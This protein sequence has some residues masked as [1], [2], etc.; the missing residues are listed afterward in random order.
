MRVCE[1]VC[2]RS[3]FDS[4]FEAVPKLFRALPRRLVAMV[5]APGHTKC[6]TKHQRKQTVTKTTNTA[7]PSKRFSKDPAKGTV[8]ISAAG[9]VNKL[10]MQTMDTLEQDAL[11]EIVDDLVDN[12][13]KILVVAR[14]VKNPCYFQKSKRVSS[15]FIHPTLVTLGGVPKAEWIIVLEKVNAAW[16]EPV[17]R[18][19]DKRYE[20]KG[21]SRL[22][23]FLSDSSMGDHLYEKC[24][25]RPLLREVMAL[26]MLDFGRANSVT[27][28]EKTGEIKGLEVYAYDCPVD[29]AY[30]KVRHISSGEV[31]EISDYHIKVGGAWTIAGNWSTRDARVKGQ[32]ERDLV[33]HFFEQAG[34]DGE[35]Y[36]HEGAT[37]MENFIEAKKDRLQDLLQQYEE[38]IVDNGE[39]P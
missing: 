17:L 28:D 23:S 15:D 22:V 20:L 39:K 7:K 34:K 26:Y 24:H 13:H 37:F 33:I 27:I 10:A 31:A 16:T 32:R 12:P 38:I 9:G 30:T 2:A 8:R 18:R 5:R 21:I 4:F 29:G 3:R 35:I 6:D 25:W 11:T 14:M 1:C 36:T 19:M